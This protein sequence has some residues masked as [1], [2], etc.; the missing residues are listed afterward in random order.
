MRSRAVANV[1]TVLGLIVISVVAVTIGYTLITQYI[2]QSLKTTP[3]MTI[4]YAKL[5]FITDSENVGGTIYVTF[6]GEVGIGNPGAD[7]SGRICVVTATTGAGTT[8]P[9]ALELSNHCSQTITLSSGYRTYS[10]ILRVPRS[11]M[12]SLGCTGSYSTCPVTR[13]WYFSV[14]ATNPRTATMERIAIVKPIYVIP[15]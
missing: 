11:T 8:P 7:T 5:I 6:K 10:F 12:D 1:V 15:T 3:E 4:T 9:T 2:T 13:N 14:Y